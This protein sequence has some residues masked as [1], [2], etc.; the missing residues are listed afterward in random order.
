MELELGEEAQVCLGKTEDKEVRW[1]TLT[2]KPECK[3]LVSLEFLILPRMLR[4][5]LQKGRE[6]GRGGE[7]TKEAGLS[8][9]SEKAYSGTTRRVK[10]FIQRVTA[11]TAKPEDVSS[12]PRARIV[13]EEI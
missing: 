10:A 12:I 13:E 8:R 1:L 2:Q 11:F 3:G 5:A 4:K 6:G 9:A 7:H